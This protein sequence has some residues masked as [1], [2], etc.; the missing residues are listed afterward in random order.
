MCSGWFLLIDVNNSLWADACFYHQAGGVFIDRAAEIM[1]TE[2]LRSSRFATEEFIK[3]M[4][5][6]FERKVHTS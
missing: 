3:L 1:L 2:K 4:V 6:E 5:E